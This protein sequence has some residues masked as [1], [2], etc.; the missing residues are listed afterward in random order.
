MAPKPAF[1]KLDEEQNRRLLQD[2]DIA[3]DT[4]A[5]RALKEVDKAVQMT[6]EFLDPD[7]VALLAVWRMANIEAMELYERSRAKRAKVL[8]PEW[9]D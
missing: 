8:H 7:R 3:E 6:R 2:R 5:I 9:F 1:P 4:D